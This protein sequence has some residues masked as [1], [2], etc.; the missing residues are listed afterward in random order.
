VSAPSFCVRHIVE[1]ERGVW[2]AE[3]GTTV[4]SRDR[5]AWWE[6]VA[7]AMAALARARKD[8]PYPNARCHVVACPS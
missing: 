7:E 1:A 2:L 4:P 5:A 8:H 6:S 3:D